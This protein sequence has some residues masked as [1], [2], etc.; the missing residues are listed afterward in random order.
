MLKSSKEK[1]DGEK[2]FE[3]VTDSDKPYIHCMI[4]GGLIGTNILH[5]IY[6]LAFTC[7]RTKGVVESFVGQENPVFQ[8][9]L[10]YKINHASWLLL[11][12]ML[13]VGIAE[14]AWGLSS[15]ILP[16]KSDATADKSLERKKP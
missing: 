13:K 1:E 11:S 10:Y 5:I 3:T 8:D 16:I 14:T 2:S 12:S 4:G 6:T 15:L 9:E 7:G